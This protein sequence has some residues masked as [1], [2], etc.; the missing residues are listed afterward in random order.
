[1]TTDWD[2]DFEES[3]GTSIEINHSITIP[4]PPPM[5]GS[6]SSAPPPPP[7]PPPAPGLPAP[8]EKEEEPQPKKIVALYPFDAD[9]PD[10]LSMA[11]GEEF[12]V[13]VEDQDGWTKVQRVDNRFFDDI[14]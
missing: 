6:V 9:T 12:V 13:L 1:M 14:G 10:T 3:D 11:E 7:P 5:Q 4:V 8:P 2:D